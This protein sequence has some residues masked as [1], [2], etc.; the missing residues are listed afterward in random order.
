MIRYLFKLMHGEPSPFLTGIVSVLLVIFG[1]L[2]GAIITV[3]RPARAATVEP[4][5]TTPEQMNVKD[6]AVTQCL[7]EQRVPVMGFNLKVVCLELGG[8]V[9]WIR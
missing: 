1:V 7:T 8:R 5:F 2:L 3:A 9:A 4:S 6:A